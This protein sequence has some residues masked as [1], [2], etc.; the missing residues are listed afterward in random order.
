MTITCMDCGVE[1]KARSPFAL[2]CQ[3]CKAE[4]N[5]VYMRQYQRS[6]IGRLTRQRWLGTERGKESKKKAQRRYRA[7]PDVRQRIRAKQNSY[8][9]A[10]PDRNSRIGKSWRERNPDKV[11]AY[12]LRRRNFQQQGSSISPSP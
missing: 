1:L 8:N 5:R 6:E 7:K 9:A 3:S 2:R 12:Q 4:K 11:K 10:H